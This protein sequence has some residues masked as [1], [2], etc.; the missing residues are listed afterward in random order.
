MTRRPL[1]KPVITNRL[2]KQPKVTRVRVAPGLLH[3]A[4]NDGEWESLLNAIH[5]QVLVNVRSLLKQIRDATQFV[6]GD[7]GVG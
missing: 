1:A 5:R 4:R 3:F 7:V 6:I 2:A